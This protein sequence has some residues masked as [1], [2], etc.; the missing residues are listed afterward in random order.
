MIRALYGTICRALLSCSLVFT[1]PWKR[2]LRRC[3]WSEIIEMLSVLWSAWLGQ[4]KGIIARVAERHHHHR[5]LASHS[6]YDRLSKF[7]QLNFLVS[8]LTLASFV[9]ELCKFLNVF[10]RW[11]WATRK[12]WCFCLVRID[13]ISGEGQLGS[14]FGPMRSFYVGASWCFPNWTLMWF[15][16]LNHSYLLSSNWY[17]RMVM[18]KRSNEDE[19]I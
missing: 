7:L 8:Y 14:S 9:E 15:S 2:K 1:G 3:C 5:S 17:L 6:L 19:C 4:S 13:K 12:V 11:R 10:V 16:R 18:V